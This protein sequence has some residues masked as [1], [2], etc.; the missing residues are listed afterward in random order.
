L[1]KGADIHV[2]DIGGR[3]ALTEANVWQEAEVVK[4]LMERGAYDIAAA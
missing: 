4:L 2:R 3:T 1:E